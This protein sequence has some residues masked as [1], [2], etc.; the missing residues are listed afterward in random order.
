MTIHDLCEQARGTACACG[1]LPGCPC[2]CAPSHY[3]YARLA[4]AVQ[5]GLIPVA[6]F[7]QVIH[8]AGD[9]GTEQVVGDPD[10]HRACRLALRDIVAAFQ[11]EL[12]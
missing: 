11:E 6:E 9:G 5:A 8:D 3:H 4:R 2:A 10:W 1:A 7:A 12:S